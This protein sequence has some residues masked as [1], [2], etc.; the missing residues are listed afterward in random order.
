MQ[1]R[2]AIAVFIFFNKGQN[3]P[4]GYNVPPNC[5]RGLE[6]LAHVDQLLVQQKVEL[7]EGK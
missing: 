6:Y 7:L 3:A 1:V 4:G 2:R 5:P